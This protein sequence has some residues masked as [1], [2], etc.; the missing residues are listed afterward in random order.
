MK[1]RLLRKIIG[2]LPKLIRY[3]LMR[4][5]LQVDFDLPPDLQFRV[6]KT[7]DELEAAYKIL[8]ESYVDMGYA[9]NHTSGLRI[10]KY[11]ALPTTTT[12]IAVKGDEVVGTMSIIREN[13]LNSWDRVNIQEGEVRPLGLPMEAAFNLSEFR[14]QAIRT[15]EIS[16]LAIKKSFRSNRGL[17]LLPLIKYLFEYLRSYMGLDAFVIAVNPRQVDFY[18][19][20]ILCERLKSKAIKE[21]NFANGA[22][23]VGLFCSLSR[24]VRN[25]QK[26]YSHLPDKNNLHRFFFSQAPKNCLFPSREFEKSLDPAMSPKML[27]YFFR[28]KSDVFQVLT[29][30]EKQALFCLYPWPQYQSVL[31]KISEKGLRFTPRFLVNSWALGHDPESTYLQVRDVSKTGLLCRGKV[32]STDHF[33]IVVRIS[34]T[35]LSRLTVHVVWNDVEKALVGMRILKADDNWERYLKF[36]DDDLGLKKV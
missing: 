7:K 24:F 3:S 2:R 29:D 8:Q 16:S 22:P 13:P 1:R 10:T 32:R 11:F 4:R 12:L 6:A 17:V 34:S 30:G 5:Q 9:K 27:D 14:S 28:E 19:G 18:E 15:A 25:F 33:D 36:L 35:L 23:A 20:L 31:P 26:Y 21:Y